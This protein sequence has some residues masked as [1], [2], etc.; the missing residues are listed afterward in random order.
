M[1]KPKRDKPKDSDSEKDRMSVTALKS[2][3]KRYRHT[4]VELELTESELFALLVTMH[5]GG[6]HAR[7]ISEELRAAA[8]GQ[9]RA[10]DS[11]PAAPV[12]RINGLTNRIGD[13]ARRASAPHDDA[14]DSLSSD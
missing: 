7:N 4:C 11:E 12:V 2:H 9:G 13:I 1:A 10:G 5:C 3:I 14:L 8:A 6:V